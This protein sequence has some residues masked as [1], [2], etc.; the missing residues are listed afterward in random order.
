MPLRASSCGAG[1]GS[2]RNEGRMLAL[3]LGHFGGNGETAGDAGARELPP[4]LPRG[5][6]EVDSFLLQQSCFEPWIAPGSVLV[7]GQLGRAGKGEG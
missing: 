5:G 4:R 2:S 6:G 7:A 1:K 3:H